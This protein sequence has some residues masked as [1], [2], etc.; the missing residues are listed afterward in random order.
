MGSN[1]SSMRPL[2]ASRSATLNFVKVTPGSLK[3]NQV[4]LP[5]HPVLSMQVGY[6]LG[7][8][9]CPCNPPAGMS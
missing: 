2:P 1:I 9:G 5:H 8:P 7:G 6:E 4:K 3:E